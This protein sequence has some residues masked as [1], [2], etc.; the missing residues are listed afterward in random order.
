MATNS[1]KSTVPTHK[2]VAVSVAAVPA[3]VKLIPS[4]IEVQGTIAYPCLSTPDP[5]AGDKYT[6]LLLIDSPQDQEALLELVGATSEQ[7][8]RS[9]ELPAGA[10]NPLRE[11]NE[12]NHAGE[13]AIKH[14][15][16]RVP[17]GM[18]IR[19]KTGFVPECVWGPNETPIGAEEITGGDTVVVQISAYG[20]ANQSQGVALSL[21]RVWLIEKGQTKI[22][23][24]T[25]AGVNVKRIDRSRLR[26]HD[27]LAGEAA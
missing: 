25:G 11:S 15:A 19:A 9:A 18:V 14:P 20:Y 5:K 26:F 6:C 21:G 3:P 12:K 17:G 7:T 10:H 2:R 13:F 24:G 16:F 23:R 4:A 22:E 1:F 27:G 8:F